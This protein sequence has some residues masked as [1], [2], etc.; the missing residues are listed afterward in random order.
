MNRAYL[1]LKACP[2]CRGDLLLDRAM[3]DAEEV[4]IQCGYHTFA[5]ILYNKQPQ[6]QPEETI[7]LVAEQ[8][9]KQAMRKL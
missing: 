2:R 9:N 1:R 8:G 5:R 6:Y 3:E 7:P 4:C